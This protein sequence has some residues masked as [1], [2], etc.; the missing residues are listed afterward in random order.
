MLGHPST[1]RA[2]ARLLTRRSLGLIGAAA[3]SGVLLGALPASAITPTTEIVS[4]APDGSNGNGES[5]SP[6]ISTSGRYVAFVS[7]AN[8]LVAGDTNGFE[9]VFVRDLQ[10]GTTVRA[11]LA[12]DESQGDNSSFA[13]AISADG[14]YVAFA[15]AA[16]N[17]VAGDSSGREDVF[18]RDLQAG[19]TQ[20][21]S[22]SASNG[23]LDTFAIDP[24]ISGDGR[25]ISF[26]TASANVLPAG[27]DTNGVTDVFV[28]DMQNSTTVRASVA[29]D[30]SEGDFGSSDGEIAGGGRYV[31]F[32]SGASN[33]VSGDTNGVTDVF[34]RDLQAGTTVRVSVSNTEHEADSSSGPASISDDGSIVA[35]ASLATKLTSASDTNTKTDIFVRNIPAGTTSFVS[36]ASSGAEANSFSAAPSISG[37]GRFV[38]FQ[39]GADNLLDGELDLNAQVDIFV[40]RL[41]DGNIRLATVNSAGAQSNKTSTAPVITRDGSIVAYRSLGTNLATITD[42]PVSTCGG[43]K[44]PQISSVNDDENCE[45]DV[46]VSS[47]PDLPPTGADPTWLMVSA[48]ALIALGGGLVVLRTPRRQP[49]TF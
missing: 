27:Q 47:W 21:V 15:S 3:T 33:L 40:R 45:A 9:D 7:A 20:R 38:V 6:E 31:V 16:S 4:I 48:V 10:T 12:D 22:V 23:D 41:S 19:T 34:V 17:L 18:I 11:S 42:P 46:F 5:S 26:M 44:G 36:R 39:S 25:Y 13:P 49:S 35:F 43:P 28:R 37:D 2:R 14:R 32:N 1:S 29:D 24:T 30:E 8:N